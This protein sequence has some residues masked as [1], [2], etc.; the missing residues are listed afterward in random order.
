MLKINKEEFDRLMETSPNI[1]EGIIQ[2]FKNNFN[3]AASFELIVKP[4]ICDILIPTNE[5]RNPWN[6]DENRLK[7]FNN[8]FSLKLEKQNAIKKI[9]EINN[10]Q[11]SDFISLFNTA[12]SREPLD[13]EILDNL[14]DKIDVNI[15]TKFIEERNLINKNNIDDIFL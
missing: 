13:S 11:I 3:N 14:R 10:K 1:P 6:N 5:Y 15:I 4:E 12:N 8:S 7:N 9:N 2:S